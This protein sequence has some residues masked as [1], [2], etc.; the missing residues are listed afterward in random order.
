MA[1]IRDWRANS[2]PREFRTKKRT[3]KFAASWGITQFHLHR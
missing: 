3:K 2:G 1:E